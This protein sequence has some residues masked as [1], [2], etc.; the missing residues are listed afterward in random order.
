MF[1]SSLGYQKKRAT[2]FW[3]FFVVAFLASGFLVWKVITSDN[4]G[5]KDSEASSS[6]NIKIVYEVEGGGRVEGNTTQNISKWQQTSPVKAIPNNGYYFTSWDDGETKPERSD[7]AVAN[8]TYKAVFKQKPTTVSTIKYVAGAGGKIE[9]KLEQKIQFGEWG[10]PVKAVPD[11]GYE[12]RGWS[13]GTEYVAR[14]D[15]G[16]GKDITH[17]AFFQKKGEEKYRVEYIIEPAGYG[18]FVDRN[19]DF[20]IQYLSKGEEGTPVRIRTYDFAEFVM[21]SDSS[22]NLE[23]NAKGDGRS[24]KRVAMLKN[25]HEPNGSI[26]HY[27]VR[28]EG[29]GD[30]SSCGYIDGQ[31]IQHIRANTAGKYVVARVSDAR[32]EFAG[33]EQNGKIVSTDI[34][35]T[36]IAYSNKYYRE[37]TAVFRRKASGMACTAAMV[38]LRYSVFRP[39]QGYIE[40][41]TVQKLSNGC[42]YGTVVRAIPYDGYKFSHWYD[43]ET[44]KM[45]SGRLDAQEYKPGSSKWLIAIFTKAD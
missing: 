24:H 23:R 43:N 11:E 18:D 42:S 21:W 10:E 22:K 32:C 31:Q 19:K 20:P 3:S 6:S 4:L 17:K 35:R 33:W 16:Q 29:V 12:F 8:K 1:N 27:K 28:T 13:A 45:Y 2:V 38:N 41:D 40:G 36:D 9:G 15:Q 39:S 14:K 44:K 7:Q 5:S 26:V 30:P 37:F 34:A 25:K